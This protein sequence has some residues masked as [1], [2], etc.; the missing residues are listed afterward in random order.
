[1]EEVGGGFDL[2]VK[3]GVNGIAYAGALFIPGS[4]GVGNIKHLGIVNIKV[5][6]GDY[7]MIA[8]VLFLPID[9]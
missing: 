2:Y 3:A 7:A 1:M 6:L 8:I 4:A 5:G 9:V